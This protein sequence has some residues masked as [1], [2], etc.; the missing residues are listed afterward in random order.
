MLYNGTLT[1]YYFTNITYNDFI[2]NR[3]LLKYTFSMFKVLSLLLY[4]LAHSILTVVM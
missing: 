2:V 1:I 4:L 3:F